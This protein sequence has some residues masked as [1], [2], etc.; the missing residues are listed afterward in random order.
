MIV[1]VANERPA[2][3]LKNLLRH[4]FVFGVNVFKSAIDITLQV[5][6][7]IVSSVGVNT[8]SLYSPGYR[9]LVYFQHKVTIF[10]LIENVSSLGKYLY[11]VIR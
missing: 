9:W 2:M 10:L 4:V 8:V 1:G 7:Y 6:Q 3:S 11:P 5:V